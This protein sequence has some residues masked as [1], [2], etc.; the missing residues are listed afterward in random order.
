[1]DH[2]RRDNQRGKG[3]FVSNGSA[4]GITTMA[5]AVALFPEHIILEVSVFSPKSTVNVNTAL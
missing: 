3:V 1:M 5:M 2:I 4:T